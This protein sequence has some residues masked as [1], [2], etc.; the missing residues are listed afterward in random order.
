MEQKLKTA[1]VENSCH[2]GSVWLQ[3]LF[4]K[5]PQIGLRDLLRELK[6]ADPVEL[7]GDYYGRGASIAI[8]ALSTSTSVQYAAGPTG[9]EAGRA[10]ANAY[11]LEDTDIWEADYSSS[12]SA[13]VDKVIGILDTFEI[14]D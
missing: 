4:E 7:N 6:T 12:I 13:F 11:D 8:W 10:I 9:R 14:P 3:D 1:L 5:R 2:A